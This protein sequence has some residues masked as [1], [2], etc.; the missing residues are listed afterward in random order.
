[1]IFVLT[2]HIILTPTQPVES[3]WPHR[4]SNPGPLYHE[5]R[6]LTTELPR[7]PIERQRERQRE[8]ETER[9]RE[10]ER[11]RHTYKHRQRQIYRD[12]TDEQ[13]ERERVRGA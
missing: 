3:G 10:K 8:R 11:E 9:E 2:G 4:E 6:A 12:R 7:P 13:K 1:M 5:S